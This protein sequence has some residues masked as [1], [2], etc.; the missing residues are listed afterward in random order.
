MP[1]TKE[2]FIIGMIGL[3]GLM[4]LA[5]ASLV[6]V[7]N[8]QHSNTYAIE[9][10]AHEDFKLLDH[11]RVLQGDSLYEIAVKYKIRLD[12]LIN[13]NPQITDSHWIYPNDVISI[14]DVHPEF[15]RVKNLSDYRKQIS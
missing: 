11:Y 10:Y 7:A 13:A 15:P 1:T 6:S 3:L 2:R 5:N 12:H 9:A 14:P 4:F 8:A